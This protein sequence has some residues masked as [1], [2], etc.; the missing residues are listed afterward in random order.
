MRLRTAE[1]SHF[2]D[3][4]VYLAMKVSVSN[5]ETIKEEQPTNSTCKGPNVARSCRWGLD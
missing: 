1:Q 3:K 5:S 4:F 2:E